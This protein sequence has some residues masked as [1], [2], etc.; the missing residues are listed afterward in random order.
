MSYDFVFLYLFLFN[1]VR[2]KKHMSILSTNFIKKYIYFLLQPSRRIKLLI[3]SLSRNLV[4]KAL[5]YDICHE[6]TYF[7]L[8]K[9]G[10]PC[11]SSHVCHFLWCFLIKF[12]NSFQLWNDDQLLQISI[13]ADEQQCHWFFNK[14]S[15]DDHHVSF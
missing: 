2:S 10:N 6:Y 12:S 13:T 14:F 15:A 7:Y 9:L 8:T 4:W 11:R 1:D 3:P 5:I